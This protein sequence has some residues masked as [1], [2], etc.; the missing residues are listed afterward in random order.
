VAL[1]LYG[2]KHEPGL[3]EARRMRFR[4]D[5]EFRKAQEL[6]LDDRTRSKLGVR[7]A[8]VRTNL[9]AWERLDE[10]RAGR[11]RDTVSA[12]LVADRKRP[13]ESRLLTDRQRR[14][15]NVVIAISYLRSGA[16]KS[17]LRRVQGARAE[18]GVAP[19]TRCYIAGAL[20]QIAQHHRSPIERA[21]IETEAT[22]LYLSAL[23]PEVPARIRFRA[24]ADLGVAHV[25]ARDAS[26]ALRHMNEAAG[27][28]A[29]LD[30]KAVPM[31]ERSRFFRN[32]AVVRY[33]NGEIAGA[34]QAIDR[35]LGIRD[36]QQDLRELRAQL[37]RR[38]AV[39]DVRTPTA[40]KLPPSMP[41]ISARI[42][43][44]GPRPLTRGDIAVK[45]EG[46]PVRFRIGPDNRIYALPQTALAEGTRSISITVAPKGKPA[47][48][49][50]E[51]F[52]VKF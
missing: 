40:S 46:R 39:S 30:R 2:A 16:E 35:S 1:A 36:K 28:L 50:N 37:S 31:D 21:R 34:V 5:N 42:T 11:F 45:I 4:A 44:G 49:V 27:L 19:E 12:V 3:A 29:D 26:G 32:L 47:V 8:L 33:R 41:I 6:A 20:F 14:L 9:L 13:A 24:L 38:P 52:E 43:P 10:G 17:A 48:T 25:H 15:L 23:S 18:S 22:K 7:V 51:S